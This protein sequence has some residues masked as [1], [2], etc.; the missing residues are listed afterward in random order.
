MAVSH[1]CGGMQGASFEEVNTML[2]QR[3]SQLC[4]AIALAAANIGVSSLTNSGALALV[5]VLAME[6]DYCQSWSLH[7]LSHLIRTRYL[8]TF[9]PRALW[10]QKRRS[11][12]PNVAGTAFL[13]CVPAALLLFYGIAG[14]AELSLEVRQSRH[15]CET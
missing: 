4:A 3:P 11:R 1:T 9:L 7:V 8:P 2:L 5:H 15:C 6:C 12:A 10:R 13:L 14:F